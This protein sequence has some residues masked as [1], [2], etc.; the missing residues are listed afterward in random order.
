MLTTNGKVRRQRA[1]SAEV[2][3][4]IAAPSAEYVGREGRK[5]GEGV[6]REER[7]EGWMELPLQR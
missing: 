7:V 3:I 1:H 2:G 4:E 5:I 6:G